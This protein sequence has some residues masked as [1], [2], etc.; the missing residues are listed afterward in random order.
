M[1]EYEKSRD[2]YMNY[3][4]MT[5]TYIPDNIL[6]LNLYL[7]DFDAAINIL[8]NNKFIP[9]RMSKH[10]LIDS[11]NGLDTDNIE[12][13]EFTGSNEERQRYP[14]ITKNGSGENTM[15]KKDI[16]ISVID[17]QGGG[18]GKS[19]VSKL[20]KLIAKETGITICALGTNS[21]ATNN[22]IKAGA[23]IGAT[24]ENAIV[25]TSIQSD[26]ILGPIAII[27]ANSMLGELTPAMALAISS[28][29]AYK[30]LIPL[31][32]CNITIA[33]DLNA[34][35]ESYIDYSIKLVM[36]YLNKTV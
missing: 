11:I 19:I 16:M 31:N 3:A 33:F 1:G 22:M 35:T 29:N 25:R 21:T 12:E 14:R 9:I 15:V 17:G 5:P 32:R 24:G 26:I 23:D 36:D 34:T 27:A 10:T 6:Y 28:C 18:I 30:I 2:T 7:K 13:L 20:R 8:S 4:K